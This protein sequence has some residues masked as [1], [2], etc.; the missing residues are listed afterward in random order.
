[1]EFGAPVESGCGRLI[2][3]GENKYDRKGEKQAEIDFKEGMK[4]LTKYFC[5]LWD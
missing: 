2:I 4:L 1:M 3:N 5:H